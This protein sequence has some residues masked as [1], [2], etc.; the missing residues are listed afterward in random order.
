MASFFC[1]EWKGVFIRTLVVEKLASFCLRLNGLIIPLRRLK[2]LKNKRPF[3]IL[4]YISKQE[5][6]RLY[7][8]KQNASNTLAINFQSSL[9][10]VSFI[11]RIFLLTT[12]PSHSVIFI[13]AS[14]SLLSNSHM[15]LFFVCW[16]RILHSLHTNESYWLERV[17]CSLD[18]WHTRRQFV[19]VV[20][21]LIFIQRLKESVVVEET[22]W[23]V[24][25]AITLTRHSLEG[26][27][28]LIGFTG[29]PVISTVEHR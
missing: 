12:C 26:K 15:T 28:P 17:Y 4:F 19:S 29:A 23:Y 6:F 22:L 14:I 2:I 13:P 27:V 25:D 9:I 8:V 10:L 18:V 24:M 11:E 21:S 20:S 3:F 1:D 7:L 16:L 5:L